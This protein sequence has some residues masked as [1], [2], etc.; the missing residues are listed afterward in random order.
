MGSNPISSGT[1]VERAGETKLRERKN[2]LVESPGGQALLDLVTRS[3]EPLSC[4]W[5]RL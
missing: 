1:E 3:G 5:W 4:S 2:L